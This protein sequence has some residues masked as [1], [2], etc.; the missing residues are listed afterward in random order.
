MVCIN[1]GIFQKM[2]SGLRVWDWPRVGHLQK[3]IERKEI[4]WW[5]LWDCFV[6][7]RVRTSVHLPVVLIM[8]K[9][10]SRYFFMAVKSLQHRFSTKNPIHSF[11]PTNKSEYPS[12]SF[13]D[14]I[15]ALKKYC[16]L[17]FVE[18]TTYRCSV[19]PSDS[20]QFFFNKLFFEA[21]VSG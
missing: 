10:L 4:L 19:S 20:R 18:G 2:W 16:T 15:L 6:Q 3:K 12:I 8:F 7:K 14:W 5:F 1:G 21:V 9:F 11:W 13:N 17:R